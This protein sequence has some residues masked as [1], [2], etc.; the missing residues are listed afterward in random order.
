MSEAIKLAIEYIDN[1]PD[2]RGQAT[3]IDRADLMAA[4]AALRAQ[5]NH[6]KLITRLRNSWNLS[7]E[8]GLEAA[9]ALEGKS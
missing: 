3:H 9:D 7:P 2:D 1:V 6:S 8:L 5:P 4:L